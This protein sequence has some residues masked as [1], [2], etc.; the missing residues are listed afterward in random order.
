MVAYATQVKKDIARW[1]ERGL[2]DS[3]TADALSRDIDA[4]RRA[5]FGFGTILAILAAILFGAAILLFV[6]ANWE[7][8]PRLARVALLFSTVFVGY[9]GGALL[10]LRGHEA[11]G[12][13]L[14]LVGAGAFGGSIALVGQMYHLPGDE[15]GAVLTWCLGTGLAAAAL[16]SGP[17]T[18]AGVAL[19]AG[20]LFM[21]GFE[22]WDAEGFPHLFLPIA[23]ALWLISYWTDS[24]VARHLLL[25]SLIS[26]VALLAMVHDTVA[27]ATGLAAGSAALFALAVSASQATEGVAR[28][29]GNLPTYGLI[30]FLV[31]MVFLQLDTEE[32]GRLVGTAAVTLAGIVGALLTA[33]RDNRALRWIAYLG[34][35]FELCFLYAVTLGTMLGTAGFLLAAALILGVLAVVIIRVERRMATPAE[36]S[37]A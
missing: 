6:A 15:A 35:A 3:G 31:G 23:A 37:A 22:S 28:I 34:F 16:R 17:L 36:G 20:W 4:R 33:G 11:L 8:M 18:A 21:R 5:S 10:K 24:R 9:V 7:V 1:V 27:V 13:A 25:L 14:W 19:A 12:E 2:I 32:V 26:Y 30:G 29:G